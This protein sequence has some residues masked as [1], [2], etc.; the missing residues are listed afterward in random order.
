MNAVNT[1]HH[2]TAGNIFGLEK[3]DKIFEGGNTFWVNYILNKIAV[4]N[5]VS[6]LLPPGLLAL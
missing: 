1:A 6:L 4:G 2:F 3:M 5:V